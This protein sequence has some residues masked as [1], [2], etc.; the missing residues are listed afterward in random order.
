VK[1]APEALLQSLCQFHECPV[2]GGVSVLV[3]D[4][5]QAIHVEQDNAHLELFH[6]LRL[7]DG[8][9]E[10]RSVVQ[11]RELVRFGVVGENPAEED[12]A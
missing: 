5:L 6:A 2:S 8:V 4:A 1:A 9:A 12:D 3:V 10:G 11:S 7:A